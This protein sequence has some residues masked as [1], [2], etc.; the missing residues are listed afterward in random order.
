MDKSFV[1]M[2]ALVALPILA[3]IA[4]GFVI[5]G[6]RF[7]RLQ[8]QIELQFDKQ[9][10][11]SFFAK[12]NTRLAELGF[13]AG[14]IPTEYLQGGR[15]SIP[16]NA[17]QFTHANTLKRFSVATQEDGSEHCRAT[18][19]LSYLDPI[20]LDTGET[21]YRDAVLNYVSGQS[22]T[23]IVV[24]NR[25]F[26]ALS[27]FVGG[28]CAWITLVV[29][30]SIHYGPIKDVMIPNSIAFVTIGVLGVI[31]TLRKPRELTG[32]WLAITGS[33]AAATALAFTLLN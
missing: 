18:L 33:I 27:S 4:V 31:G 11:P 28:L 25:S 29:L 16:V 8:K 6:C 19:S 2:N 1:V 14:Q 10:L 21:T 26:F 30:R 7:G 23:M 3:A 22:D 9:N 12:L 32:R 20:V 13:R 17:A 5:G 15:G 24:P